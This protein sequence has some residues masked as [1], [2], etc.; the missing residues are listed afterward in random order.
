[1]FTLHVRMNWKFFKMLQN[2]TLSVAEGCELVKIAVRTFEKQR[3]KSSFE[4]LWDLVNKNKEMCNVKNAI[5]PPNRKTP[6][7][8]DECYSIVSFSLSLKGLQTDLF[9]AYDDAIECIKQR[10]EP[11]SYII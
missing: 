6:K 7:E 2:S 10:F 11:T 9:S 1:M 5:L 4:T 3:N 8:W